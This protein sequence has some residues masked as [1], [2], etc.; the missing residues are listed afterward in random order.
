MKKIV[1]FVYAGIYISAWAF[2]IWSI[3]KE[4]IAPIKIIMAP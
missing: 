3:L 4:G 1:Y 2:L